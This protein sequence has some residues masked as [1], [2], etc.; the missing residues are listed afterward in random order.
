MKRFQIILGA[1]SVL[2]LVSVL[3]SS[4]IIGSMAASLDCQN[5]VSRWASDGTKTAQI[6]CFLTE[7]AGFDRMR[8]E[9]SLKESLDKA[10]VDASISPPKEGARLL[11]LAFSTQTSAALSVTNE[12]GRQIGGTLNVTVNACGGDYFIFHPLKML[13][14]YYFSTTDLL[15][16]C[17]V[18]DNDV[19]WQFFGSSDVVGR[20]M[21]IN[22]R[23]CY[24]SG[25]TENGRAGDYS[26]F[27]G[28]S[29]MIYVPYSFAE[30]LGD[31]LSVTSVEV[32]LPDPVGGFALEMFKKAM[33]VSD[34]ESEFVEN[35]AR[36]K[37][38]NLKA[39]I[40]GFSRR[41]VR[42][43]SVTFPFY[44]NTARVLNDRAA[45]VFVFKLIPLYIIG[46]VAACEAVI[47]YINRKRI[48]KF[49]G[50]KLKRRGR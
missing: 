48:F 38:E 8:V 7:D 49:I 21:R 40:R 46:I 35:S 50:S 18:I 27:Y 37:D 30:E 45:T 47:L 36:F 41:S 13:S 24:I 42:E 14:G 6:S 1:V 9:R 10:L 34:G 2:C 4:L 19:A 26:E 25:V 22:G 31:E 5:A 44:E 11:A 17:I 32:L 16:D 15:N 43:K 28:Q 39:L 23:D 33:S 29:P 3:V 12:Y 20:R